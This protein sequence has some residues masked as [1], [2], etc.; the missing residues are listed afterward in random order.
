MQLLTRDMRACHPYYV[1]KSLRSSASL[2]SFTSRS[3]CEQPGGCTYKFDKDKTP[4]VTSVSVG[5]SLD[6]AST[7]EV[8]VHGKRLYGATFYLEELYNTDKYAD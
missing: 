7:R 8:V 2:P 4:E 1:E 6:L 3:V 5:S